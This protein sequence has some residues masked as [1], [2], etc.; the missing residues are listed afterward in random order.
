VGAAAKSEI[1]AVAGRDVPVSNPHKVYF[2]EAGYTKLDLVRY[3]LAVAPGALAGAG[4]RPLVLKRYVDGI[5][6]PA[7]YQ[8]RAPANRPAWIETVE[9]AFPSGRTATEVVLRDAAG[10]VY[11]VNLGCIELHPYP[12]RAEDLDHPD[13]L[14][15]DLDP[16]PGVPW[17]D[18]CRV[19]QIC[20]EVLADHALTAFPKTSGSRG[21]H[22]HVRLRPR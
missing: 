19:A 7:F 5:G 9:F 18:V 10:L 6:E 8:K 13:E 22:L 17:Q 12:V 16:V 21:V 4:G 1:V 15:V 20:R 14:R 3:Y 2:P 11:V